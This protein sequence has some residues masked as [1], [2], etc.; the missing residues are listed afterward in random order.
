MKKIHITIE[1]IPCTG[2]LTNQI[3]ARSNRDN[4][5]MELHKFHG[6]R[7]TGKY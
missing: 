4:K 1:K 7:G 5:W 2:H 6:D 3:C